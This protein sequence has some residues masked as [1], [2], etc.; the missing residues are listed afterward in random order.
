MSILEIV[1]GI[2]PWCIADWNSH[3][4]PLDAPLALFHKKFWGIEEL[5]TTCI[6]YKKLSK[7]S[8]QRGK[9]VIRRHRQWRDVF[10]S[11]SWR[12]DHLV[13]DINM[14]PRFVPCTSVRGLFGLGHSY[15]WDQ[16]TLVT[17]CGHLGSPR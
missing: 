10:V 4:A 7:L 8:T 12:S 2:D 15:A 16:Q 9:S 5:N 3:K 17:I 11:I 6:H 1:V 14:R 13:F